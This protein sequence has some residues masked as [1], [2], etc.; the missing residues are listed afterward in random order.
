MSHLSGSTTC[1]DYRSL[2]AVFNLLSF[3]NGPQLFGKGGPD[4]SLTMVEQ[5]PWT[6]I[7]SGARMNLNLQFFTVIACSIVFFLCL[8]TSELIVRSPDGPDLT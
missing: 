3:Q 5:V 7:D 1:T 4:H 6:E 8:A 2:R